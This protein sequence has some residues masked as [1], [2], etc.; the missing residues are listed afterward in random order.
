MASGDPKP[1][2]TLAA[3]YGAGGTVVGSRVADE[4]GV[5]F[6]DRSI[7][8]DVAKQAGLP[9]RVVAQ[10]DETPRS[11]TERLLSGLG[12][13]STISG[14]AGGIVETLDLQERR[15]RGYIEEAMARASVSGGVVLGRGGMVVLRDLPSAL[16]VH[17]RG[18]R[19]ARIRQAM[20]LREL[21]RET[22]ESELENEDRARIGYVQRAYGVDGE[23]PSFYH[24]IIDSTVL[25]LATCVDVIVTASRAR[26]PTARR[27]SEAE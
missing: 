6:V 14:G 17:L 21:D 2:V 12:R 1:V 8:E 5:P 3:L 19:E 25:D 13:A 24:L 26:I 22:A 27:V 9:T 11:A 18:P 10:V 20:E 4:L 15:L 16:H 23:D 7:P